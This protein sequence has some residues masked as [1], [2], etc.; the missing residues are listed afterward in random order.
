MDLK[1]NIEELQI[2]SKVESSKWTCIEK[3]NYILIVA[4]FQ[5]E[6]GFEPVFWKAFVLW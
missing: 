6:L 3:I 4:N 5:K 2:I 1:L